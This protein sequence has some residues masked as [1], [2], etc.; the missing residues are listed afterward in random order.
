MVYE[1]I[2]HYAYRIGQDLGRDKESS[3]KGVQKD[4][5]RVTLHHRAQ[6]Y[7]TGTNIVCMGFRSML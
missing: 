5:V 7:Q 6:R 4:K 2:E 1:V 3:I